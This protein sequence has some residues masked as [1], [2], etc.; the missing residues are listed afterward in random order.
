MRLSGGFKDFENVEKRAFKIDEFR[1]LKEIE[2][3]Y[4][5]FVYFLDKVDPARSIQIGFTN[6]TTAR[7]RRLTPK[8]Y[9]RP[10]GWPVVTETFRVGK[11]ATRDLYLNVVIDGK[12]SDSHRLSRAR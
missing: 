11:A 1:E 12:V 3:S 8:R 10:D 2:G 5:A 9:G 7:P 4:V 6:S